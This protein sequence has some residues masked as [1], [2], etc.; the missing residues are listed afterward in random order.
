MSSLTEGEYI[1]I[2]ARSKTALDLAAGN[3]NEGT[4]IIGWN[5]GINP[6]KDNQIWIVKIEE[7]GK[8]GEKFCKLTNKASNT[9]LT[10]AGENIRGHAEWED[11][12]SQKW[13][14]KEVYGKGFL[15]HM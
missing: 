3:G 12:E 13:L 11:R 5:M 7:E 14:F 4:P 1:I 8:N 6:G 15:L 2:N 10:A 9:I